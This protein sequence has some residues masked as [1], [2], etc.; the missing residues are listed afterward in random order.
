MPSPETFAIAAGAD[1]GWTQATSPTYPPGSA[2]NF[3][4]NDTGVYVTRALAGGNFS[5]YNGYLKWNTSSLP[6]NATVT[7]AKVRLWIFGAPNANG[8]DL[9]ADWYTWTGVVGDWTATAQTNAI[10]GTAISTFT[11][12]PA[13]FEIDLANVN[14]VS[15]TGTTYLRFHISGGQP[16]GDNTVGINGFSAGNP[17]ELVVTYATPSLVRLAPDAII[18]QTNLT[19][20]VGDIDEDPDSGDAS[21]LLAP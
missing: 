3:W 17:A 21:W 18:S 16:T 19:G 2:S 20:T 8:R 5:I 6:D 14:N 7:A 12:L 1:N 4:P 9:T 10:S 13:W 11:S 15:L